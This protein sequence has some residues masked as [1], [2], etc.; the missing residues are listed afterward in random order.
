METASKHET[1]NATMGWILQEAKTQATEDDMDLRRV[2]YKDVNQRRSRMLQMDEAEEEG[3]NISYFDLLM[4]DIETY[5]D[6]DTLVNPFI[7]NTGREAL[8]GETALMMPFFYLLDEGTKY[9]V[10]ASFFDCVNQ[11]LAL[12]REPLRVKP[13]LN[14]I[15]SIYGEKMTILDMIKKFIS[16]QSPRY[17]GDDDLYEKM[18]ALMIRFQKQGA[19]KASD[20]VTITETAQRWEQER[21]R[22]F[23]GTTDINKLWQ[24]LF[25]HIFGQK[26]QEAIQLIEEIHSKNAALFQ[27]DV[28]TKE[29]ALKPGMTVC[30]AALMNMNF[31]V[32][33]EILVK[34][35]GK[36][37]EIVKLPFPGTNM[38]LGQKAKEM[39]ETAD[40]DSFRLYLQ[41]QDLEQLRQLALAGGDVQSLVQ[42]TELNIQKEK[43]SEKN[44]K[45]EMGQILTLLQLDPT[46]LVPSSGFDNR[47]S[48]KEI[49]KLAET[50]WAAFGNSNVQL[51][52]LKAK[53]MTDEQFKNIK[54]DCLFGH[55]KMVGTPFQLSKLQKQVLKE[56]VY[57]AGKVKKNT[58]GW[59]DFVD[60]SDNVREPVI[61]PHQRKAG[62]RVVISGNSPKYEVKYI[63]EDV[64]RIWKWA[65]VEPKEAKESC[66]I[67][68]FNDLEDFDGPIGTEY[69]RRAI[70]QISPYD[71]VSLTNGELVLCN[72]RDTHE[73]FL[74]KMGE[75]KEVYLMDKALTAQRIWNSMRN[76]ATV[77][78]TAAP[79]LW[80]L[81][82]A[83]LTYGQ[84]GAAA[85]A[86]TLIPDYAR[87]G[88]SLT[89]AAGAAALWWLKYE[90]DSGADEYLYC[91]VV[92]VTKGAVN[93]EKLNSLGRTPAAI[94]WG[95]NLSLGT[96]AYLT[97]EISPRL[98]G[99]GSASETITIK[100]GEYVKDGAAAAGRWYVENK[101]LPNVEMAQAAAAAASADPLEP[102]LGTGVVQQILSY[103]TASVTGTSP[104]WYPLILYG[105][106]TV[107][108]GG[109]GFAAH[110]YITMNIKSRNGD[111]IFSSDV[112]KEGYVQTIDLRH[113]ARVRNEQ[114]P[115][116][117]I[118]WEQIKWKLHEMV[119]TENFLYNP[120]QDTNGAVSL[121]VPE[122]KEFLTPAMVEGRAARTDFALH[123]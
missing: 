24:R 16:Q 112:L 45:M 83:M 72:T 96:V 95:R 82:A 117:E 56:K 108:V 90:K 48:N 49:K 71:G 22:V 5:I 113:D 43:Q 86:E 34:A 50:K 100:I 68:R 93:T 121:Y 115:K 1:L 7:T 11:I 32:M 17:L 103:L 65:M 120:P 87:A 52:E 106:M 88:M 79:T 35:T 26:T 110:R 42:Q 114:A 74:E 18:V 21:K 105:G 76:K 77:L 53:A 107:M 40:R 19:V 15:T 58:A 59:D 62:L 81:P 31:T 102:G 92:R 39:Y 118:G 94:E 41:E 116:Y 57:Y 27:D 99:L 9:P 123:F 109:M 80:N 98:L 33:K 46:P 4:D 122:T 119:L 69:A 37:P 64:D 67:Y 13:A 61:Q 89:L 29:W 84:I 6:E 54:I 12:T 70:R 25:F 8:E 23:D 55:D 44:Q 60:F 3:E 85:A 38:N 63:F 10:D 78:A 30:H 2:L 97:L 104:I 101:V 14:T 47:Y 51:R 36:I 75:S 66:T 91:K 20:M 73:K 28:L 111:D